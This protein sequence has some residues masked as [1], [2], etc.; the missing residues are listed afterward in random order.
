MTSTKGRRLELDP[1]E[2]EL[3]DVVEEALQV[4]AS[5]A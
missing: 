5:C 3:R 4:I 1:I 2:I